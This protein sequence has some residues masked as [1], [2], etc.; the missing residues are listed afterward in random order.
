[1]IIVCHLGRN[2]NMKRWEQGALIFYWVCPMCQNRGHPELW[3]SSLGF[4]LSRTQNG[5]PQSKHTRTQRETHT[6]THRHTHT[7]CQAR[8]Q[9]RGSLDMTLFDSKR[10]ATKS[11]PPKKIRA[12]QEYSPGD[13]TILTRVNSGTRR[14]LLHWPK[15]V[16]NGNFRSRI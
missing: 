14:L 3:F 9:H 12:R 2:L 6:Q 15:L 16:E 1:M 11:L 10:E 8:S 5:H 13:R 7:H 4:P